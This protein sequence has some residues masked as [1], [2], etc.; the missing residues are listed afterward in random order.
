MIKAL[1]ADRQTLS[2]TRVNHRHTFI[3][4]IACLFLLFSVQLDICA[5]SQPEKNWLRISQSKEDEKHDMTI[6]NF[7]ALVIGK[8]MVG[9][10]D[11]TSLKS[12]INGDAWALDFGGGYA[13]NWDISLFVSLGATLGH[14]SDT[15]DN[16]AAYYPEAGMVLELSKKLGLIVTTRR[17]HHLYEEDEKIIMM[18]LVFRH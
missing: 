10:I 16:I 14:N 7:G 12:E 1:A 9:H 13:F 5:K 15:S 18:G 3:Q 4:V 2:Q 8:K 11:L 6:T 17:Y